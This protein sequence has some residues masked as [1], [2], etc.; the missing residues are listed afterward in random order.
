M[1]NL[2]PELVHMVAL[3]GHLTFND[4]A[5]L[6]QTCRRMKTIFVDD[7][8][9]RDIHYALKG[10]MENVRAKRW[11]SARYAL[12]R[13]WF[14]DGWENEESVWR[15][16]ADVVVLGSWRC[17]RLDDEEDVVGWENVMLA[18]LS[19]P[20]ASGCLEKW[21]VLR[22][23]KKDVLTLLHVAAQVGSERVVDWV[24]ER[25]GDLE[26][27][28]KVGG[29][30]LSLASSMGHLGVVRKLVEGGAVY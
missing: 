29:T 16:I 27:K 23:G 22:G 15:M 18:A 11:A 20:K 19:L 21:R 13:R 28:N 25:G 30:P 2:A 5:A 12:N 26:V 4:I 14:V 17:V 7:D 8:Y 1:D 24:V 6:S 3:T 9:G 10:V